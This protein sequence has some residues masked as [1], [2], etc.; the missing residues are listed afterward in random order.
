[1]G[2]GVPPPA[3]GNTPFTP[4]PHCNEKTVSD[5][6][7]YCLAQADSWIVKICDRTVLRKIST[8][9][10]RNGNPM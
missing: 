7:L 3:A 10:F 9:V 1:M 8:A 5:E 6:Q 4:T 2:V